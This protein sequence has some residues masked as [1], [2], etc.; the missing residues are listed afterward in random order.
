MSDAATDEGV[1][2]V[3]ADFVFGTDGRHSIVRQRANLELKDFGVP[4]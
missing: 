4:N 1:M 2:D 3:R